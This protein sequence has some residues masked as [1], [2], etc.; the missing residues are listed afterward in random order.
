[1][2]QSNALPD[3]PTTIEM[4]KTIRPGFFVSLRI[5]IGI[6]RRFRLLEGQVSHQITLVFTF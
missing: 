4:I 1:M 6:L 3:S 2:S 5:D